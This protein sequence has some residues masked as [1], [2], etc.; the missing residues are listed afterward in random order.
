MKRKY[1]IASVLFICLLFLTLKF[2]G[3]EILG[4]DKYVRK[5]ESCV[6]YSNGGGAMIITYHILAFSKKEVAYH[7]EDDKGKTTWPK[8][9]YKFS[10]NGSKIYIHGPE[11][12]FMLSDIDTLEVVGDTLIAGNY[13]FIH[14]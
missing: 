7:I 8:K 2:Y 9:S 1:I 5:N 10:R 3:N 6:E 12:D 14:E 11:A 13:K 4:I